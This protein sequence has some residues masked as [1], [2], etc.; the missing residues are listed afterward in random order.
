MACGVCGGGGITYNILQK[1]K[2]SKIPNF[3][4]IR[5]VLDRKIFTWDTINVLILYFT[6]LYDTRAHYFSKG[7]INII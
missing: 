4:R 7:N 1:K 3:F 5:I 2:K 6:N